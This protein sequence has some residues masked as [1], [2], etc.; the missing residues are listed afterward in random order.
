MKRVTINL[1]DKLFKEIEKTAKPFQLT[2]SQFIRT[3]ITMGLEYSKILE[4]QT[5]NAYKEA[6]K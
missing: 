3:M 2:P 1:D 4:K 5:K 6:L